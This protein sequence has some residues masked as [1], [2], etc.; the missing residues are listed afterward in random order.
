MVNTRHQ[1][2][3]TTQ[4]STS[5][6]T[7]EGEQT[8][9]VALAGDPTSNLKLSDSD[10]ARIAA[11]FY[12]RMQGSNGNLIPM[13]LPSTSSHGATSTNPMANVQSTPPT[14]VVGNVDGEKMM[15]IVGRLQT[16]STMGNFSGDIE[17][18]DGRTALSLQEF[19]NALKFQTYGLIDH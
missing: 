11:Q 7:S 1:S 15:K 17:C 2:N 9:S 4:P 14:T 6:S 18:T 13:A 12:A 8:A 16:N 5:Q 19:E 3:Q 10:C